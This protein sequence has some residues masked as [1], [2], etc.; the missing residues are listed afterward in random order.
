MK[1]RFMQFK[2]INYNYLFT[3]VTVVMCSIVICSLLVLIISRL[4]KF[5]INHGKIIKLILLWFTEEPNNFFNKIMLSPVDVT[6][7][8]FYF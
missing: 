3:M 8:S 4:F 6:R 7:L 1:S 5:S 2:K